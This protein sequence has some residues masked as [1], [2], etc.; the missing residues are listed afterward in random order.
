MGQRETQLESA[1][2]SSISGW[3]SDPLSTCTSWLSSPCKQASALNSLA[4]PSAWTLICVAYLVLYF[5]Q[6][7][8]QRLQCLVVGPQL[9]STDT[10]CSFEKA[11]G[12]A[13]SAPHPTETVKKTAQ[14]PHSTSPPGGRRPI[15]RLPL[16]TRLSQPSRSLP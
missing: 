5:R 3:D 16:E 14:R 13:A 8:H 11:A 9:H 2:V 1:P 7:V 10:T 6:D 15:E 12:R 4:S